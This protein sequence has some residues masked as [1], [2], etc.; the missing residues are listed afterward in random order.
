MSDCFSFFVIS[1]RLLDQLFR[2]H[3]LSYHIDRLASLGGV[4]LF[5]QHFNTENRLAIFYHPTD[6]GKW[7]IA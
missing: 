5:L 1:Y 7:A 3:A 2:D 4:S 6:I